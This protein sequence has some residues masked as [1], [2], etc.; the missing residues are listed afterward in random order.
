M[1][2]ALRNPRYFTVEEYLAYERQ[3]G[4]H[5]EFVNGVIYAMV[6]GTDR[7]NLIAGNIF[8]GLRR[9]FQSPCQVFQQGM[10]VRVPTEISEARYIPD[11]FASCDETDRAS[12]YRGRPCVIVEVLSPSTE[13]DDRQGKFAV[14]RT[15]PTLEHYILVATDVPQ[16]EVFARAKSW[17][18]DILF[19]G[20]AIDVCHGKA[21]LTVDAMYEEIPF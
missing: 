2:Q 3:V 21:R 6:G 10:K 8:Y 13:S 17:K 11:V 14:Y 19:P 16:V 20:D 12:L 15:I 9:Q 4:T 5:L 18:P 1:G 7:H